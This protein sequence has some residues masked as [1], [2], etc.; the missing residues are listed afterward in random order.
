MTTD[1]FGEK[2]FWVRVGANSGLDIETYDANTLALVSSMLLTRESIG[3][4]GFGIPKRVF[5]TDSFTLAI[6]TD[7][8]Y[9]VEVF[10]LRL[11]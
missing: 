8:G 3:R 9:L 5:M 11:R 6:V 10:S 4:A 7:L 2:I 1:G